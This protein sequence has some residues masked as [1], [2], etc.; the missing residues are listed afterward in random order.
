M[1][2]ACKSG[3][4]PLVQWLV[5]QGCSIDEAGDAV[6]VHHSL[7][8]AGIGLSSPPLPMHVHNLTHIRSHSHTAT[9]NSRR[10]GAQWIRSV[11]D[12]IG[13]P[14]TWC[15][16][17]GECCSLR[18]FCTQGRGFAAAGEVAGCG[19]RALAAHPNQGTMRVKRGPVGRN[20]FV[21]RLCNLHDCAAGKNDNTPLRVQHRQPGG[22]TVDR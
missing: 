16:G 14:T 10:G 17:R 2:L 9:H 3:N 19:L 5:A 4:L 21:R 11:V 6:S 8:L 7:M 22:G 15:T 20:R 18:V 12:A 13:S 1:M